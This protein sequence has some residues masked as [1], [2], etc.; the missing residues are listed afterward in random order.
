MGYNRTHSVFIVLGR[1]VCGFNH[2][3][4]DHFLQ[5]SVAI[6]HKNKYNRIMKC[7]YYEQGFCSWYHEYKDLD[8]RGV[9]YQMEEKEELKRIIKTI[10]ELGYINPDEIPKIDLYMDQVTTFMDE[11][12]Q[13]SKRYEDNK[14]LT[15]TMINNYS[16]NKLLPPSN[17][18]KYSKN[19]VI[20]LI[21][22]Y[23]LK[24]ILTISD[25]QS[26]IQPLVE[27]FYEKEE[28]ID[29]EEIYREI[30][31]Y[32]KEQGKNL[33]KDVIKKYNLSKEAF[34]DIKDKEEK[35]FL[36]QFAYVCMLS[37]DIYVKKRMIE[38]IIDTSLNVPSTKKT[39]KSE[40]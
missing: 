17:K 26:I 30:L 29:L 8:D 18:K 24:N 38:K 27:K 10:Q 20:L 14:T 1:K 22:I 37:Y 36:S 4:K 34:Q 33:V 11:Y 19:H 25:I 16:K 9:S 23:Y 15:K 31:L 6:N 39:G 40:K 35:E 3:T 21:F 7:R 5:H 2:K 13:P 32:E 28:T 12:L